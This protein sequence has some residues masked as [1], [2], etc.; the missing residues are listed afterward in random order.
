MRWRLYLLRA[1]AD[2][3]RHRVIDESRPDARLEGD[4]VPG[5]LLA[6]GLQQRIPDRLEPFEFLLTQIIEKAVLKAP[7]RGQPHTRNGQGARQ[8]KHQQQLSS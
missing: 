2:F 5:T 7:M 3:R 6:I 4:Q 8:A 1:V